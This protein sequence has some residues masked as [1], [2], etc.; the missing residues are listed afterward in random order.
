MALEKGNPWNKED[1][2]WDERSECGTEAFP[3]ALTVCDVLSFEGMRNKLK[4]RERQANTSKPKSQV[5]SGYSINKIKRKGK[6]IRVLEASGGS[7]KEKKSYVL[8]QIAK[9]GEPKQK[10]TVT[11]MARNE[12][13]TDG[14]ITSGEKFWIR[15]NGDSWNEQDH[16]W[17]Q[18][19]EC[20]TEQFPAT[21]P[22][23]NELSREGM[24]KKL[25]AKN[26]KSKTEGSRGYSLNSIKHKGKGIRVWETGGGKQ[27]KSYV[28][29]NIVESGQSRNQPLSTT[30]ANL[31][32][33]KSA[34]K[35]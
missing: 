18:W 5:S 33:G 12:N 17:S 32:R 14:Y 13:V 16:M 24:K 34:K 1:H 29:V 30:R 6:G 27:K 11:E 15:E 21:Y 7:L 26:S 20:G 4:T 19:S 3:G 22:I 28:L 35:G 8:A 23:C 9:S 10:P 2:T 25:Q 31:P